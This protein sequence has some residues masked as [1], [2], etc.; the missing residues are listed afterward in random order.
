MK[1]KTSAHRYWSCLRLFLYK[2][3][4]QIPADVNIKNVT[5]KKKKKTKKILLQSS[6]GI[7]Q[8]KSTKIF[9]YDKPQS[10]RQNQNSAISFLNERK[11]GTDFMSLSSRCRRTSSLL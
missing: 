3:N 10:S 6:S 4:R 5:N 11:A 2:P 9:I 1:T 7:N 8:N